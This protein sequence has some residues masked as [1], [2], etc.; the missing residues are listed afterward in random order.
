MNMRERV[1]QA[2]HV[3]DGLFDVKHSVGGMVD[4]EF[5][6]QYL[7]LAH[8][9]QHPEL[10]PNLGN[11]KLI[12]IAQTCGLLPPTVSEAAMDAYRSLRQ[13]QHRARLDEAPTQVPLD[14]AAAYREAILALWNSVFE[15]A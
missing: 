1:R 2:H 8:S 10:I 5:V 4:A 6:V 9:A 11:I 15:T 12:R 7:L 13:I 14:D 3:P